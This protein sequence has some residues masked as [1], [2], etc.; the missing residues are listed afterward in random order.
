MADKSLSWHDTM[1]TT[2]QEICC[3]RLA[4]QVEEVEA[5]IH[6]SFP[7]WL[8]GTYIQNGGGDY[9][10]MGHIADGLSFVSKLRISDG[11]VWG[12]QRFLQSHA[13]K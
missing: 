5:V 6:G 1:L 7:S 8:S 10:D 13:Y 2:F 3:I 12:S 11:H 9:T 4:K